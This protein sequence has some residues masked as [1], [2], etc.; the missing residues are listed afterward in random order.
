[1]TMSQDHKI[2]PRNRRGEKYSPLAFDKNK[3]RTKQHVS[4]KCGEEIDDGST[5]VHVLLYENVQDI[6]DTEKKRTVRHDG[7]I[8]YKHELYGLEMEH[9]KKKWAD[10]VEQNS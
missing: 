7:M 1:M 6:G 5:L 10:R 3:Y 9:K 2:N 8:N 4:G